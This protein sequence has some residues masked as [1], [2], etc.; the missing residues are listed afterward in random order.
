MTEEDIKRFEKT[1]SQ[2]NGLYDEISLLSKKNPNDAVNKFK[3]KFINQTLLDANI[4]LIDVYK[5][6][7]IFNIFDDNDLPT[8]SDVTM[9]LLQYLKCLEKLR[10]DN[11]APKTGAYYWI[12]NDN[13]SNIRTKRPTNI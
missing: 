9:I 13:I 12:I 4:L 11:I 6:Y 10:C 2:I 3:L 8:T 1:D 5:P 7:D